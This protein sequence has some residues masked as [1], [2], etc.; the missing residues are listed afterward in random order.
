MDMDGSINLFCPDVMETCSLGTGEQVRFRL[1][2]RRAVTERAT[3]EAECPAAG[4]DSASIATVPN[5][6]RKQLKRGR[7]RGPPSCQ[8]RPC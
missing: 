2:A 8:G 7:K 5:R 3:K 6:R 4:T 1:L